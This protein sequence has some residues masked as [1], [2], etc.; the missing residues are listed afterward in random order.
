M[1]LKDIQW[2]PARTFRTGSEDSPLKFFSYALKESVE[3]NLLLGYFSSGSIRVLAPSFA[4]FLAN[5][6]TLNLVINHILSEEDKNLLKEPIP[7]TDTL[8]D[9]T[10]I[11]LL[12][13]TLKG[14]D[15]HF[16]SCLSYLIHN[17]RINFCIIQPLKG[18][19]IAHHKQGYFKDNEKNP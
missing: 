17:G 10:D 11:Q 19:G 12:I 16:F 15:K 4:Y 8:F 2:P 6:G 7:G 13:K 14:F 3:L 18:N 5:G 9:L 1:S